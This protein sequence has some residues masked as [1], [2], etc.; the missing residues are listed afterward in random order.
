[1]N[2]ALQGAG[3]NFT[4]QLAFIFAVILVCT[5]A[6]RRTAGAAD[7]ELPKEPKT[8]ADLNEPPL[9]A[10][11]DAATYLRQVREDVKALSKAWAAIENQQKESIQNGVYDEA[12]RKAL[13]AVLYRFPAIIPLLEKAAVCPG[14][15][16]A[17]D[18]AAGPDKVLEALM[19][20]VQEQRSLAR[21]LSI[22][23]R[24]LALDGK[25]DEAMKTCLLLFRLNRHFERSPLL[26]GYLVTV[27]IRAVAI[28][29]TNLVLRCGPVARELRKELDAELRRIETS[30]AFEYALKSERLYGAESFRRLP[31]NMQEEERAAGELSRRMIELGRKSYAEMKAAV[32][33][34]KKEAS[35]K[36]PLTNMLVPAYEKL[37]EANI[38][39]VALVR[40]LRVLVA[41]QDPGPH[42]NANDPKTTGLGLP[43]AATTDPYTDKPLL[44]KK[45]GATGSC[46]RSERI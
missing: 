2:K 26:I 22:R 7:P 36:T 12:D 5:P 13:A 25:N 43:P 8:L 32:E 37:Q 34:I 14:Y 23:A 9:P 44:M 20:L 46:T 31:G 29:E 42:F 39:N 27:A 11:Q 38:R 33:Q 41:V 40:C 3:T 4:W 28:G 19:P 10:E 17:L 16:P 30:T 45:L 24:L 6:A 35:P 21:V 15:R 18:F 1:M